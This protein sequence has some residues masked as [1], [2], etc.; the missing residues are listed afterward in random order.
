MNKE[1][2]IT[3]SSA[4]R[5]RESAF[6]IL[7]THSRVVHMTINLEP[8][9]TVDITLASSALHNF[10]RKTQI[11]NI[12]MGT[13]I[14]GKWDEDSVPNDNFQGL[15]APPPEQIGVYRMFECKR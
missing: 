14:E 13:V 12:E 15:E 7:A 9:R 10:L 11:L 8:S 3:D 2:S 5:V 1:C 4:R 6:G